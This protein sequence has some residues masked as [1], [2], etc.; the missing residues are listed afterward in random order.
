V[1]A[2]T[3]NGRDPSRRT[4]DVACKLVQSK[5]YEGMK[6][7]FSYLSSDKTGNCSNNY[8]SFCKNKQSDGMNLAGKCTR[9][10]YMVP[11]TLVAALPYNTPF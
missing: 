10:Y 3:C 1:L 6:C 2:A 5:S 4:Y 11:T 8:V 7:R 9:K